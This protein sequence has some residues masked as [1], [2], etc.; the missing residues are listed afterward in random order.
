LGFSAA[1]PG[2]GLRM[3]WLTTITTQPWTR[4]NQKKAEA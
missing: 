4:P 3:N 1:S 2:S